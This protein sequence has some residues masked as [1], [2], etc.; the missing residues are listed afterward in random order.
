VNGEG[1]GEHEINTDA[2]ARWRYAF[3]RVE[4]MQPVERALAATGGPPTHPSA[5]TRAVALAWMT[6]GPERTWVLVRM[7][8]HA[9]M[10]LSHDRE[11]CVLY[12]RYIDL[13]GDN[14]D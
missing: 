9:I 3:N 12:K 4:N 14:H 8:Q 13:K 1:E 2:C 7:K 10:W 6:Y 5:R 11:D